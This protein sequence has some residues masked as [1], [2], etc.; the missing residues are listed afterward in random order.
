MA[1]SAVTMA[2]KDPFS[3]N[4]RHVYPNSQSMHTVEVLSML[5]YGA[6]LWT[7]TH[8]PISLLRV[9]LARTVVGAIPP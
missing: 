2:Y 5:I 7:L 9:A 4:K 8:L 1:M 6:S 3:D